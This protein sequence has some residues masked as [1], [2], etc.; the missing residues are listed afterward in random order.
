MDNTGADKTDP[1]MASFDVKSDSTDDSNSGSVVDN[2]SDESVSKRK[3]KCGTEYNPKG[4]TSERNDD[5]D[6]LTE[7]ED[8]TDSGN[9]SDAATDDLLLEIYSNGSPKE[10]N[11][12]KSVTEETKDVKE[13]VFSWNSW[14]EFFA[15]DSNNDH[16][17]NDNQSMVQNNDTYNMSNHSLGTNNDRISALILN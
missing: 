17:L 16:D 4:I 5:S 3:T 9:H 14:Q 7:I 6:S 12:S 2:N 11:I 15:N 10:E 1:S 13:G 8:I